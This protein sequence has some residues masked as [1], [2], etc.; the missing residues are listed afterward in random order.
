MLD[1]LVQVIKQFFV[2]K[3]FVLEV[4]DL[5]LNLFLLEL[6]K[7]HVQVLECFIIRFVVL[8]KVVKIDIME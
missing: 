7:Y 2:F 6:L 1:S 5:V 3:M 4:L 8:L